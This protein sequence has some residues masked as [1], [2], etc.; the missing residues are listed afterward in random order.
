MKKVIIILI[1]T[2]LFQVSFTYTQDK[3]KGGYKSCKV[4]GYWYKS[5]QLDIESKSLGTQYIYDEAGNIIEMIDP[6]LIN[7]LKETYKFDK[8]G[9]LL[10]SSTYNTNGSILTS[11]YTYKYDSLGNKIE[12]TSTGGWGD[13]RTTYKYDN[14]RNMV[15]EIA[16]FSGNFHHK[17]TYKYDLKG[18]MI[19]DAFYDTDK[20]FSFGNRYKY[21][22][23]GRKIE[24]IVFYPDGKF[25]NSETYKYD[26]NGNLIEKIENNS[27]FPKFYKYK[28]DEFNNVLEEVSYSFESKQPISKF[29]YVYAK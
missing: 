27:T 16:H 5:N 17:N 26:E 28:Y 29:E 11:R 23:V 10:E 21:N 1:L 18:N 25:G 2:S 6:V 9:I 14:K 7:E 22:E 19:E 12:V 4:Y 13:S 20:K 3:I 8:N 24:A 15:E